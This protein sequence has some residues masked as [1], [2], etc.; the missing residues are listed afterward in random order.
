MKRI[1]FV[2]TM[3]LLIAGGTAVAEDKKGEPEYL[4]KM[5]TLVPEVGDVSE[6]FFEMKKELEERTQGRM[7]L[8]VYFGGVMGDEPDIIK[9]IRLGQ[10]HGGMMLTLLGLGHICPASKVLQ[11]P[12][13]FNNYG[14][15]DHIL[16]TTRPTFARLFE[17]KG[18]YLVTWSEIGFGY[19][20]FKD[21]I[22][23]FEDIKKIKMVSFTGDPVFAES[24]KT[25]GFEN[26]IPLHISET[27]TGL[28]TGLL[29]GT[30]GPYVSIVA[31]QWFSYAKY[32]LN[33]PFSYSPGGTIVSKK[34]FDK[35]PPDL[36]EI[37]FDVLRKREPMMMDLIRKM[38]KDSYDELVQ[39][40]MVVIGKDKAAAITGEMKKGTRP[41][42]DKLVDEYYPA[43]LLKE[44]QNKLE[45]YRA[46]KEAKK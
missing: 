27:L 33:V 38:E 14:E 9:K 18:V 39:H 35:I 46:Q 19:F 7:K 23:S 40:G 5:A 10:L 42:Y 8:R 3:F 24:E 21:P 1:V 32:A 11:L 36:K 2:V 28:Q 41:L 15:V 4:I 34:Y 31:L 6:H 13:L 30:F 22:D 37:F 16:T 26:L 12:F 20:V 17:E 43:S 25:A 29:Q 45:K 44:I